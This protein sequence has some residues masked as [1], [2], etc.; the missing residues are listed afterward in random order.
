MWFLGSA[1]LEGEE[2]RSGVPQGMG[3][4]WVTDRLLAERPLCSTTHVQEGSPIG[5]RSSL[6]LMQF[7][8]S[9]LHMVM[10]RFVFPWLFPRCDPAALSTV[11]LC[12]SVLTAMGE[13]QSLQALVCFPLPL[14][15]GPVLL[16][17]QH[18]LA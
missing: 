9:F 5:S 14:V 17:N 13:G 12:A 8:M 18:R 2:G 1:S 3:D 6:M 4:G 10:G 15:R 16:L 7:I 11:C